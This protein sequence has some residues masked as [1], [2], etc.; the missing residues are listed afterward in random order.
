MICCLQS[1]NYLVLLI[2]TPGLFYLISSLQ[3]LLAV[4]TLAL[5]FVYACN[6]QSDILMGMLQISTSEDYFIVLYL[7]ASVFLRCT[8]YATERVW[9]LNM[10]TAKSSQN[11]SPS[12]SSSLAVKSTKAVVTTAVKDL[13]GGKSSFSNTETFSCAEQR[14]YT[15]KLTSTS[16]LPEK[17]NGS[18]VAASQGCVQYYTWPV[19]WQVPNF[20]DALVYVFYVPLLF[21]G[22]LLPFKSFKEQIENPECVS[23]NCGVNIVWKFLRV[24]LWFCFNNIMLH[25]LLFSA[26]G[27]EASALQGA[28]KWTIITTA[29]LIGQF[30][31]NKYAVIYGSM[32]QTA[33]L[34][35]LVLAENPLCISYI[36]AYSDMW[37]SFD[38]G[39]YSCLKRYIFIPL[40]GSQSGVLRKQTALLVT[41]CF[42]GLWHG[43]GY[44]YM[45]W[46][47]I[48][49]IELGLE[50]VGTSLEQCLLLKKYLL[51]HLSAAGVRRVKGVLFYPM[52]VLSTTSSMFL[53]AGTP[54]ARLY[55]STV[56]LHWDS[57]LTFGV[58]VYCMIQNSK[59]LDQMGLTKL[60]KRQSAT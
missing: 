12:S 41:F 45:I 60:S 14:Q 15:C 26:C 53:L 42:M 33:R 19:L 4:W 47:L 52:F 28:D 27:E 16:A 30:M 40:G 25:F 31:T 43:G 57:F 32:Q 36:Y 2:V 59:H 55:A 13:N 9:S 29:Y 44:R 5:F 58:V 54:F 49:C 22:P 50:Q 51:N 10:N 8:C 6:S 21:N 38:P 37:K 34:D 20:L 56:C 3:S 11:L 46:A 48:N 1:W 17:C 23:K 35:G 39:L 18:S 24:C 7:W